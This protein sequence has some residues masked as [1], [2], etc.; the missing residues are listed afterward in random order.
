MASHL[1][2]PLRSRCDRRAQL[3]VVLAQLAVGPEVH[4][5][6][7]GGHLERPPRGRCRR[8]RQRAAREAHERVQGRCE[9]HASAQ[10]WALHTL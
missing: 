7:E 8:S 3:L 5:E 1:A 4:Q 9:R 2:N 10:R 6:E